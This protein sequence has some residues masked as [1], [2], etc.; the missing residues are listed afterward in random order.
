MR[1]KWIMLMVLIG[2]PLQLSAGCTGIDCSC[3]VNAS[4]VTF[5]GYNPI[6]GSAA[7]AT[8]NVAVTCTAFVATLLVSY[9]IALDKGIYGT[10]S[11]RMMK[12]SSTL[13]QY[14]LYT[15][16]GQTTVWGDGTAGTGTVSDSYLLGI[17]LPVT[18]NYSV[19]G[20]VPASQNVTP[21]TYQDTIT[22]TV[23]Y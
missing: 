7:T 15:S 21:G 2:S 11:A 20:N 14:N 4:S 22:V 17:L 10:F 3:S 19:Y 18:R 8:G 5:S 12:Y 13:L 23:T 1:I 16:V 9:N 6:S